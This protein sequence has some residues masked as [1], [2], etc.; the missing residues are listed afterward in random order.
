MTEDWYKFS[1][2]SRFANDILQFKPET[3]TWKEFYMRVTDL[4]YM[5]NSSRNKQDDVDYLYRKDKLL[6]L[7]ICAAFKPPL[8]P[9]IEK[10]VFKE[11]INIEETIIND[12]NVID[13]N[14]ENS[15]TLIFP[16][17]PNKITFSIENEYGIEDVQIP[18]WNDK[19]YNKTFDVQLKQNLL[20][21]NLLTSLCKDKENI[22]VPLVSDFTVFLDLHGENI[23]KK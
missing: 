14:N 22:I 7:K 19:D 4:F 18:N 20:Q 15:S 1:S 5:L 6:E 8:L 23:E 3:M 17:N 13:I 2:L 9:S 12:S 21:L 16:L 10:S 11:V